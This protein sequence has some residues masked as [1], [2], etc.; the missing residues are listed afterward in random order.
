MV[1]QNLS[2]ALEIR[3]ASVKA[4]LLTQRYALSSSHTA[5]EKKSSQCPLC[6]VE[7]ETMCHFI[8]HCPK[9]QDARMRY[10]PSIMSTARN[11]YLLTHTTNI[12]NIILDSNN[13]PRETPKEVKMKHEIIC[14]DLVYKL[15][16]TRSSLLGSPGAY[17]NLAEAHHQC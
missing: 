16:S 14:R 2:S 17:I 9:L 7:P 11:L 15:H 6:Q 12:I 1:W 5:G 13:L 4:K 8:L 10:L 3:I